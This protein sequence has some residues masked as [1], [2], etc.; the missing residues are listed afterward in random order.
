MCN[1]DLQ[2]M[3]AENAVQ[4]KYNRLAPFQ[5]YVTQSQLT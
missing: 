4:L 5:F 1:K 3:Q 2:L